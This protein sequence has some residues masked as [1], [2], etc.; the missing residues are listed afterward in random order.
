M[1]R[2]AALFILLLLPLAALRAQ[3]AEELDALL[4]VKNVSAS[5]AA[6]FALGAA[7]LLP[8]YLW[9]SEAE[10]NAWRLATANGWAKGDA[11][12]A[13]TMKDAAFIL[14]NAFNFPGGA[15][16]RLF[17]SP[18]YAYREM[19]YK[20]LIQGKADPDMKLS[21]ERLLWIIGRCLSH[22]GE[23]QRLDAELNAMRQD[24]D[25]PGGL[26]R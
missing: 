6:R 8:E 5:Q 10:E 14:M 25:L 7:D 24:L 2:T 13:I 21:G 16:Y 26:I 15:M 20:K 12:R 18:R 3:T 23:D 9:G 1:T 4:E 22:S 11:G 19:V 17:P